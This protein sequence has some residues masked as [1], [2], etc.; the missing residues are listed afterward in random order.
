M[1][2]PTGLRQC[3]FP[4]LRLEPQFGDEYGKNDQQ[5]GEDCQE[6]SQNGVGARNMA[7]WVARRRHCRNRLRRLLGE[8]LIKIVIEHHPGTLSYLDIIDQS[9]P[10]QAAIVHGSAV[11]PH[12]HVEFEVHRGIWNVAG[13]KRAST[14]SVDFKDQGAR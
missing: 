7:S 12:K 14:R 2:L 8:R 1:Q 4:P 6:A 5:T 9:S 11:A 13:R 10:R 3:S